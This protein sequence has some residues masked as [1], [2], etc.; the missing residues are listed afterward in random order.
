M[1]PELDCTS[2]M[3]STLKLEKVAP[4]S[5]GSVVSAPSMAKTAA[6]PR[7]P[8]T[9]NCC[10]K[11]AAPLVSVMVPAARR[12]SLLKSRSLRSSRVWSD[13]DAE[14][15]PVG[16]ELKSGGEGSA[17]F[18]DHGIRCSPILAGNAYRESVV[19]RYDCSECE[20][21]RRRGCGGIFAV[22]S[23]RR[24]L[25]GGAP[26]G[27]APG[28]AQDAAPGRLRRRVERGYQ[29]KRDDQKES[30][31]ERAGPGAHRETLYPC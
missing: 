1:T 10:V 27:I 20:L 25:D 6:E 8:L 3:A 15:L 21:A 16:R 26:Y 13:N 29:G 28:V 17:V 24:E 18:D 19:A 11:L 5:S 23:H 31:C 14:F 30:T 2:W 7:W 12:R 4:P 9:A 22:G